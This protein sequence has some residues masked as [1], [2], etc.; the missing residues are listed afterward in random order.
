LIGQAQALPA[1]D[2]TPVLAQV[3]GRASVLT[4]AEDLIPFS[5]DGTA[6]LRQMPAAVVFPQDRGAGLGL[7]A[8]GR[9]T[10]DA[11]RHARIRYRPQRG[12][13]KVRAVHEWLAEIGWRQPAVGPFAEPTTVTYHDSCHL[14]HGQRVTAQPRAILRSL[15]GVRLVDLSEST[16]CCGAAGMYAAVRVV[17]P[18]SLLAGAYQREGGRLREVVHP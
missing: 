8:C 16:W 9:R 1:A 3:V 6:S 12:D 4:D 17:H 2:L 10:V 15:P 14:A 11:D 18:I 7:R 13:G 5:F